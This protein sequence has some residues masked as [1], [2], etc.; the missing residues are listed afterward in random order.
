MK[1]SSGKRC[2][3]AT[4]L[5]LGLLVPLSAAAQ[6][7]YPDD[8][9]LP[10]EVVVAAGAE[11]I[12]A[13]YVVKKILPHAGLAVLQVARGKEMEHIRAFRAKGRR[14]GLNLLYQA[15]FVP[16]DLMYDR[17][18]NFSMIQSETAWETA[19]GS[20][21]TVAVLDT[22]LRQGGP[23]GI[24]CVQ[25]VEFNDIVNHDSDPLDG[26]G[27]GTHVAGTIA[28][29]TDNITGLA[30]LAHDACIMPVKILDDMGSGTTADIAEGVLFAKD[31]GANVIN[32]SLGLK[33]QYNITTDPILEPALRN[34]H[35]ANVTIVCASGN[36]SWRKNVSYPAI[37]PYTIAVGA[38]DIETRVASYSN[39]GTGLDLVAPGG[40]GTSSDDVILQETYIDEQ[41]SYVGFMGTSMAAPHVSAAAALLNEVHPGI[42]PEEVRTA[43]TTT[44]ED[45]G[46][47]GY[48]D[49]YGNGLLMVDSALSLYGVECRD[50][51]L[52]GWTTCDD[53]CDDT[54]AA[55]YPEAAEVCGDTLDNNCDGLV[56][57]GCESCADQDGDGWTICDDDCNDSNSLIFPGAE[58]ICG[59]GLDN[60]CD[61]R[62]DE[63]C[64]DCVDLDGDGWSTCDGDC[65]DG[66]FQVH[67]DHQDIRGRW[68]RDGVDNDCNGVIDG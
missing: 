12:P 1:K 59:D 42:A 50:M 43:L 20:G 7:P 47:A 52:D 27:H 13:G 66:D 38:V 4:V 8:S 3:L 14:A 51:D 41:W 46:T 63:G 25:M 11:E 24:G 31:N 29:T 15:T 28:Q 18:W 6:G 16:N 21:S 9:F 40:G 61:D 65:D 32:M 49:D 33:A 68:G 22:G 54:N 30:G 45:L 58:E 55:V 23:D 10:G 62:V 26:D 35:E 56:D 53:D 60:D 67:P 44:A 5:G 19:T 57:E 17:Q 48:D 36:D 39:G 37:S 2:L 64:G 34:A